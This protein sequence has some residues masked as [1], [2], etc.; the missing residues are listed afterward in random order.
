MLQTEIKYL[1]DELINQI[2]AGEVVERPYNVVKELV[3][4]AIDAGS[5]HIYIELLDGGKQLIRIT[6]NGFGMSKNNLSLALERHATSKIRLFK[7]LNTLTSFGFRGEALPSIASV[8]QFSIKSRATEQELGNEIILNCGKKIS[9]KE[10]STPFG[11]TVQVKDLFSGV[12][13][14]LKFLKSTATEFSHIH[15]FLTAVSLAFHNISFRLSHN[16]REIFYYKEKKSSKDRFTEIFNFNN[17]D[18]TE[19]NFTRGSFKLTGFVG[20]PHTARSTPSHFI[21]F[22]NG[23]YVKDKIVRSGIIQAYQGL[24][25]KGMIAP[26]IVFVEVDPSWVDVNA[27]PSKVEV[28]FYD[29]AVI[30][31]LICMGIQD[32]VKEV[33]HNKTNHLITKNIP[34]TEI[35]DELKSTVFKENLKSPEKSI[36]L[37]NEYIKQES[38]KIFNTSEK[39]IYPRQSQFNLNKEFSASQKGSYVGKLKM[40]DNAFEKKT[41]IN[42][43][44][45]EKSKLTNE[46][47]FEK[48]N[49]VKEI[50][51][52]ETKFKETLNNAKLFQEIKTS[53]FDKANY[54]G[55]FANCFL[56][57]EI[58]KELW[59]ID[60]HAFHE[61][62]L[63]EE[64]IHSYKKNVTAKQQ[65]LAPLIIPSTQII[66]DI[67]IEEKEKVK[68]LGFDI[69]ALKN[70]H[71]A[72]HSYPSFI[73]HQKI[74]EIFD[75]IIARIISFNGIPQTEIHPLIDKAKKANSELNE[76][77]LQAQTLESE[78]VYHLLFATMACHSAIRAGDPLNEELVKRLLAR[79]KDVDFYAHCPHGRPVI[80][81]FSEKDISSWFQRT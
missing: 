18:Y 42:E 12:P 25:L 72:I 74:P 17:N 52:E 10:V 5:K 67:I 58:C 16:G 55:Q 47:V 48:S 69:E 1:N 4:N 31:D 11:T 23:R 79:A 3:E 68:N 39:N 30:Q 80:R 43:I 76:L 37:K 53:I 57:L 35:L 64:L 2:K 26:A 70:G 24:L 46:N 21:T 8:S 65:L 62:I 50:F 14:R 44:S 13:V 75:E 45:Q 29:N 6:D 59:I 66:T 36:E 63:F 54:L 56:L 19:I 71:I 28:R 61:R 41:F 40:D 27:H 34:K 51:Q 78:K 32:R 20:L 73:N 7:D 49:L 9:E 15:D 22:V 81:K 77:N 33:I 60:Q 38:L